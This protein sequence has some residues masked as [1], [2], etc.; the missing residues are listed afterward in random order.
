MDIIRGTFPFPQFYATCAFRKFNELLELLERY[1]PG[2]AD[3]LA[4]MANPEIQAILEQ[5]EED[6][7]TGRLIPF[8][9]TLFQD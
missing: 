4:I 3:T 2:L 5:D 1:D 8:D 7:K 6:I 9:E